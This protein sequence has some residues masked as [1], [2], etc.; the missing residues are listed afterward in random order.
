MFKRYDDNANV[1]VE[2]IAAA[3]CLADMGK[4]T[5]RFFF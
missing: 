2:C 4:I 1:L 3:G 5:F